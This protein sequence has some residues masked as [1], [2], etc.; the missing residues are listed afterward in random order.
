MH[1]Y[2]SAFNSTT[3][4][5]KLKHLTLPIAGLL[6]LCIQF[7]KAQ[8]SL[9]V[10][11]NRIARTWILDRTAQNEK[12]LSADSAPADFVMILNADHTSKQGMS[13]DGLIVSTWSVNE[14]KMMLT[15]KDN[16]T[17]QEYTMKITSLT[18]SELV[19]QDPANTAAAPIH[20]HAN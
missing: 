20:Y 7:T 4:N 13:P 17:A 6:L 3:T 15:I 1:H 5:S 12:L 14:K 19:L 18:P 10:L 16:V 9:S 11:E 2:T 8:A